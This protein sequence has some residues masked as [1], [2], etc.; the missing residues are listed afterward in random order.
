LLVVDSCL[1]LRNMPVL[2]LHPAPGDH[3][4]SSFWLRQNLAGWFVADSLFAALPLVLMLPHLF[5][6]PA[7]PAVVCM[8]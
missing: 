5:H 1:E 4:D 2:L 6:H 7:R 8:A 3:H